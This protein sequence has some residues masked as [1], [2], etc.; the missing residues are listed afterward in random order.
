MTRVALRSEAVEVSKI[1]SAPVCRWEVDGIATNPVG[2]LP[3]GVAGLY[4]TDS[5]GDWSIGSLSGQPDIDP[6]T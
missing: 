2:G 5:P 3:N 6:Q 1:C 4:L